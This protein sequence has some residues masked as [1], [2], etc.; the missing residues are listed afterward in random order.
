MAT[1]SNTTSSATSDQP[2]L[3]NQITSNLASADEIAA[4]R[5]QTLAWLHQ[6]RAAQFARTA[7]SLK[8]EFGP[9]DPGVKDAESAAEAASATAAQVALVRHQVT[10]AD[11]Q[12]S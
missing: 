7:A 2:D 10:T 9:D 5:V 8:A 6:A 4:E 3:G 11:P 12:V 1:D